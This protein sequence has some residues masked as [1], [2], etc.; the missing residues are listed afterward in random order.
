MKISGILKY[1]SREDVKQAIIDEAKNRE[2]APK[3]RDGGFGKRPQVLRYPSDLEDWV[4]NGATSFHMSEE[5]WINPMSISSGMS[6]KDMDQI[7]SGW[8]LIFDVDTS[9]FEYGKICAHLIV[10]ALEYHDI[11]NIFVKFSGGTGWHIAVPYETFPE[12]INNRPVSSLFPEAAQNI[13]KYIMQMVKDRLSKELVDYAGSVRNISEKANK[14]QEELFSNGEFDP[15]TIIGIDSVAIASRHLIRMTYSFNEKTWLVSVPVP[16]HKILDF[17]RKMAEPGRVRCDKVFIERKGKKDEAKWLFSQAYD[18]VQRKEMEEDLKRD[19][20]K[21]YSVPEKAIPEKFFPPCIK[22]ILKGLEDGR[23]RSVFILATFLRLS[24]W[25]DDM[26]EKKIF[27]WNK[28]NPEPLRPNYIKGQLKWYQRNPGYLP[29]NC[30]NKAYYK[31]I[32]VCNPDR[33]CKTIKNPVTY[34]FKRMK[35]KKQVEK[36]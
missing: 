32:G 20:G 9:V 15:Y 25:S 29:P 23:K 21:E 4:R 14:K 28:K 35:Y 16:R 6:K 12:Q 27:E 17:E 33:V 8:D 10:K 22:K 24:G 11:E 31:D 1:Y 18:F 30:D 26:I 34:S 3:F 36:K 2:I 19:L 13:A 7:R 5:R